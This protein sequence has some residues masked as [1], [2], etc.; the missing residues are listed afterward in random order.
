M[1]VPEIVS[2]VDV[3]TA[4][5]EKPLSLTARLSMEKIDRTGSG[6]SLVLDTLA[7]PGRKGRQETVL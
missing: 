5:P 4:V 2:S 3:L 1:F 7:V 6:S